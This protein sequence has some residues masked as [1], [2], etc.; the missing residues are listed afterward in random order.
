M[1][2]LTFGTPVLLRHMTFSEARKMPIKEIT[3]SR[4]LEDA[5]LKQEEVRGV[6][7]SSVLEEGRGW[8]EIFKLSKNVILV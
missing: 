6:T 1:D 4:V 7:L 8:G 5:G 2:A 3:L